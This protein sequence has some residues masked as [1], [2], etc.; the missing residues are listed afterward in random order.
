[1][2]R[3]FFNDDLSDSVFI[4]CVT[5]LVILTIGDPDLLDAITSKIKG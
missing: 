2:K 1:M 4:V 5:I 3:N